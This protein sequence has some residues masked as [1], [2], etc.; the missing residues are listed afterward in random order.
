MF[1]HMHDHYNHSQPREK[2]ANGPRRDGPRFPGHL[3]YTD[4]TAKSTREA[5]FAVSVS[6][7]SPAVRSVLVRRWP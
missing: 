5:Q 4:R 3:D 6:L 7:W 2:R 1:A